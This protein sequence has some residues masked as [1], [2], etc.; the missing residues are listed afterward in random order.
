MATN[1]KCK[2]AYHAPLRK[3]DTANQTVG[4]RHTN[5]SICSKNLL[6]DV[7]AFVRADSLCL[8]PPKSWKKQYQKLINEQ[9]K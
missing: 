2:N 7:C 9:T 6:D 5:P 3:G 8:A 4:C 1:V